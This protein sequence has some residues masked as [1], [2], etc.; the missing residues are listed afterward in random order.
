MADKIRVL[1]A[2]GSMAGGGAERQTINYLRHLDR[3][4]F[5]PLLYL[6]YRSGE[7]LSEVPADVRV[8]AFWD[9]HRQPP[10]YVP[11]RIHRMQVRDLARL[12]AEENIDVLCAVTFLLSLVAAG[13]V[14]Q[15]PTPWLAVEMADP[16]LDFANQTRRFRWLKKRLLVRAYGAAD[17]VVAVSEGVREGVAEFHNVPEAGIVTVPNFIDLARLDDLAA[18]T[19]TFPSGE[20]FHITTVGR[21]DRQKGHIYLLRAVDELVHTHGRRNVRLHLLGKG[22]LLGEL[23]E[24]VDSRDLANYVQFAGYVANPMPLIRRSQLFCLSSVYEGLPLVLLEAMACRT[25][26]VATD[27]PSGPREV[28]VDGKYGRLVPPEDAGALARAIVDVMDNYPRW[29]ALTEQARAHVENNYSAKAVI[30]SVEGLI[31]EVYCRGGKVEESK[32]RKVQKSNTR[33]TAFGHTR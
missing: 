13:G 5:T 9:R 19:E 23:R 33:G 12:L 2:I 29:N 3:S 21:L 15:R 26:V 4:R 18:A 32:S 1:F 24:F 7:L 28:L 10:V 22:P 20:F 25:P 6:H 11:G 30:G 14:R 17:R 8:V 27:C 16:R 31:D